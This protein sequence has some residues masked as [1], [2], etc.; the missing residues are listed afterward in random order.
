M[1]YGDHWNYEKKPI[2]MRKKLAFSDEHGVFAYSDE[3]CFCI[4]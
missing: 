3:S 2:I 1:S 4:F